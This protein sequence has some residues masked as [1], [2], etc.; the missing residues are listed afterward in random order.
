MKIAYKITLLVALLWL[1][2]VN[3]A[4]I[5]N[6][7]TTRRMQMAHAWWT[8]EEEGIS[9]D[10]LIINVNGKNYVPYDLGQ[11]MLM[12]PGDWLGTKL[13]QNLPTELE[14]QHFTEAIV[15]FFIFLPINLLAVLACFQLLQLF[16]YSEKLAGLSSLV[17]LLGTS[18]LFYANFHQQNNQILLF[19]LIAYQTA[20]AYIIKSKKH[21]AIVSGIV[22]GI[23]FLIRITSILH[24]ISVLVFLVG[25]VSYKH[26]FKSRSQSFESV[27][28]WMTGFIPFV[29]LER[30]LT[31]IR[32]GSWTATSTSLH[33]QIYAKADTL[34]NP[35]AIVQGENNGFSFLSLL[36][37]IQPEGLLAPLFSLEKS[38]F[39]Y[40]PLVLP[41]SLLALLCWRFL[42]T[43]IRWYLIAVIFNFLLHLYIYSWT[44][45]WI[46]H[47]DWGARYHVTSVHLLLVPLI[48]L[49]IRGAT[50]QIQKNTDWIEVSLSWMAKIILI[51]SM[52]I[53]LSSILL[54]PSLEVTQQELG[55]G[56]RFRLV[57]RVNNIFTLL[58]YDQKPKPQI[59][60]VQEQWSDN[61]TWWLLPFRVKERAKNSYLLKNFMPMLIVFWILTFIVAVITTVWI[62]TK[63]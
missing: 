20:L 25:C 50:K 62:F 8:G 18:V 29:L 63:K 22:V 2:V 51:L 4:S 40:D 27:M 36:T 33:L 42:S 15:S 26:K 38:I 53:Q 54:P 24:G 28:L 49:L 46:E 9:G 52:S 10:K 47:E 19:I 30:I 16:G 58:N 43:Y 48:P 3:P 13:G 37:K 14:R 39:L 1:I 12:L 31:Y 32:Y 11:S 60:K 7:D 5:T 56:S 55:V 6:I 61:I 57:Q 34:I 59:S 45:E 44:Y 23:A 17:L 35:D 41:C 21:L